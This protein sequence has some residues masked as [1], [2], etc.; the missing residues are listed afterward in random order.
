M[1]RSWPRRGDWGNRF[2]GFGL[3]GPNDQAHLP[4]RRESREP[5]KAV[6]PPRSGAAFGSALLQRRENQRPHLL[7]KPRELPIPLIVG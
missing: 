2:G 4:R 7:G 6:M 5:W 1:V 3:Q